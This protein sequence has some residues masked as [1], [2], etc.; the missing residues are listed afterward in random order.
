MSQQ[1]PLRFM[2][3]GPRMA[4]SAVRRRGDF[5]QIAAAGGQRRVGQRPNRRQAEF[6]K[7]KFDK[8]KFDARKIPCAALSLLARGRWREGVEWSFRPSK[9]ASPP[10]VASA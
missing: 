5:D 2:A 6:F 4:A 7:R 1:Y 3:G 9:S 8:R 10:T